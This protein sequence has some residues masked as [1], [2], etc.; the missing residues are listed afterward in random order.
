[1]KI[2]V[3]IS[4]SHG[5]VYDARAVVDSDYGKREIDGFSVESMSGHRV[6]LIAWGPS[7]SGDGSRIRLC[8]FAKQAKIGGGVVTIKVGRQT[9][10]IGSAVQE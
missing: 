2:V 6:Y 10:V 3:D 4:E 8:S 1:M 7:P 9:F 5:R